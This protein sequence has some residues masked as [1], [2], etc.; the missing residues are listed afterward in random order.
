MS[1]DPMEAEPEV[2]PYDDNVSKP[3]VADKAQLGNLY[4]A[5]KSI[6][7]ALGVNVDFTIDDNC[8]KVANY[9]IKYMSKDPD[10]W[11]GLTTFMRE[12][13]MKKE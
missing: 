4:G 13:K 11:L 6:M 9:L 2:D 8:T 12:S 5:F 7:L 1:T 3:F 10:F